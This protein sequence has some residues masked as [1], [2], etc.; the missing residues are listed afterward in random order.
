MSPQPDSD[1]L[2]GTL[3][4]SERAMLEFCAAG[5]GDGEIAARLH[6]TSRAVSVIRSQATTKLAVRIASAHP[7]QIREVMLDQSHEPARR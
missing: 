1:S 2:P 4:L 6:V 5:L 7:F 3:S